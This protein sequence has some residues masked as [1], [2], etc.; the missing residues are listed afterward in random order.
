MNH[1]NIKYLVIDWG[2]SNFRA[3]AIGENN[4][5]IDRKALS[6]GLLEVPEGAFA[7]TLESILK[8]WLLDYRQLPIYM[9]GMVGSAK[10]WVNVDYIST[11]LGVQ[12]LLEKA[13]RS[14]LPWGPKAIILPGVS[15]SNKNSNFEVMRGEEIQVFGLAKVKKLSDFA[16]ILPGTHSKHIE[17]VGDQ[18][19]S[20]ATFMTGEL[21]SILSKHSI[22]GK[23][24]TQTSA[25]NSDAFLKGVT[26]AQDGELS[27]RLFLAR[28]SWLFEQISEDGVLDY[29]SGMLIGFELR[30]IKR[31]AVF[32]VGSPQL[33][34]RYE[35]ACDQLKIKAEAVD[36]DECF[37]AGMN[38]I[39]RENSK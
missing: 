36:G 18:I 21:Y 19:Q 8:N 30:N 4:Q 32:L 31:Q 25:Q 26:D 7:E 12:D 34:A 17:Y 6:Q 13:Y 1:D 39:Y 37:L 29:L 3:F 10:G 24:F 22:L 2:T 20:I 16:A 35:L 5:L 11:P 23:G 9:A 38:E 14:N 15:Y 33:C 27:N 28:T